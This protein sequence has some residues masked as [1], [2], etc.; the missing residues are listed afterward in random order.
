MRGLGDLCQW[1]EHDAEHRTKGM[2]L[3]KHIG[4]EL[5]NFLKLPK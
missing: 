5:Y 4:Y 2:L 1:V 3:G